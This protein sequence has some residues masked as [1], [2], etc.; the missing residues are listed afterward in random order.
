MILYLKMKVVL[1]LTTM[2]IIEDLYDDSK[3]AVQMVSPFVSDNDLEK[4][5]K[6]VQ[7]TII[8]E[9]VHFRI[10]VS[11]LEQVVRKFKPEAHRMVL[12]YLCSASENPFLGDLAMAISD[13][14][15]FI[16]NDKHLQRLSKKVFLKRSRKK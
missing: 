1:C 12:L 14:W 4:F 5:Q 7:E 16:Y 6:L 10:D 11:K 3:D 9:H 15:W 2:I 13:L 8:R